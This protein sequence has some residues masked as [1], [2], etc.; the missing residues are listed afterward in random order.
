MSL[1]QFGIPS[2]IAKCLPNC[3]CSKV[4]CKSAVIMTAVACC[5]YRR[6]WKGRVNEGQ[7]KQA[8]STPASLS[9]R[10]PEDA[11]SIPAMS[12]ESI[13]STL[14]VSPP[15]TAWLLPEQ[16]TASTCCHDKLDTSFAESG[17]A[18]V[19]S[20]VQVA[21]AETCASKCLTHSSGCGWDLLQFQTCTCV[22]RPCCILFSCGQCMLHE[23]VILSGLAAL[24]S[25]S[26]TGTHV[27]PQRRCFSS[28]Y[29][30]PTSLR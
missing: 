22:C 30:A 3:N 28:R 21:P 4:M 8:S 29:R 27:M 17:A 18:S 24:D 16:P 9:A 26:Y 13:S 2:W 15:S 20:Q 10:L 7:A 19:I 5:A 6:S 25:S 23:G 11:L 14:A 1:P 12:F